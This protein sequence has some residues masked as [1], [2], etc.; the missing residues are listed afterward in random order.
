MGKSILV[1]GANKGIGLAIC[2]QI[3]LR[4][5]D[6]RV[7][8]GSRDKVRG[9]AAAAGL[10]ALADRVSVVVM[11]VGD[12]A[13]V[14]AAAAAIAEKLGEEKLYAIVNNAGVAEGE[15]PSMLNTNVLGCKRVTE[16]FVGLVQTGGRIVFISSAIGP[17]FVAKCTPAKQAAFID[18]KASWADIEAMMAAPLALE[19]AGAAPAEYTKVGFGEHD[20]FFAYGLSKACLNMYN[21]VVARENPALVVNACTPGFIETDL[22]RPMAAARG[23]TPAEMGMKGTEAGAVS[24]LHLLFAELE[25]NG[26]Y[27]GSDA[28]RSPLDQYRG[29]GD[30]PY[31]G[32]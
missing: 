28:V 26:R 4:D 22:T 27:Y 5:P 7:L 19:K 2:S 17:S 11:D 8:L 16:A 23:K 1:T 30:P 12:D 9:E 32:K 18:P 31:T 25:G 21:H 6:T 10:G 3:L 13:S 15:M 29:P 20:G 14:T 24:A